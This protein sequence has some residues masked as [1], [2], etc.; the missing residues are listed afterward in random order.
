MSDLS[1]TLYFNY[2]DDLRT[3]KEG[4]RQFTLEWMQGDR[5]RGQ[6]FF[7][8]PQEQRD[9]LV[10]RGNTVINGPPPWGDT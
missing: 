8:V 1:K 2:T 5:R 7:A 4:R 10:K 3:D 9:G 6:Y